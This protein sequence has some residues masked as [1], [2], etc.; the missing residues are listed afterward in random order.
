M[1]LGLTGS[2]TQCKSHFAGRLC[3]LRVQLQVELGSGP[4]SAS[5]DASSGVSWGI[6]KGHGAEQGCPVPGG[7][8]SCAEG[9]TMHLPP[10]T[11]QGPQAHPLQGMEGLFKTV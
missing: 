10:C 2:Y 6:L 1:R 4:G 9:R 8:C 11:S 7:H 5:S 3:S